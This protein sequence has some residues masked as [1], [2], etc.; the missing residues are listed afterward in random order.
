[1]SSFALPWTA[2]GDPH[3]QMLKAG[4]TRRALHQTSTPQSVIEVGHADA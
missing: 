3:E 4:L 1:M 2:D